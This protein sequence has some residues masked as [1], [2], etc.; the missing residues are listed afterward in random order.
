MQQTITEQ[1]N[2]A[3]DGI[4]RLRAEQRKPHFT[5]PEYTMK[6]IYDAIPPHCLKSNTLLSL[7]YIA[8][9]FVQ[10]F[11]L[12]GLATF[13][14]QI[15]TASLR[16]CAWAI[17]AFVQGLCFTGLWEIAHESGHGALS[18]HKWVN[19]AIGMI[20]HSLLLVPFHSW[21]LTHAQ[22]HKSTN[23]LERDIAFVP[24]VK[25]VYLEKKQ[26]RAEG[27]LT[28]FF[29]MV[30]DTPIATMAFLF[31]HQLIAWPLYLTINNRAIPRIAATP[32]Y[33]GSHFYTGGDGPNF[34]PQNGREILIS[35]LGIGAMATL[36]YASV[37]YFG[38]W[39]V[40]LIYLFPWLWTN[41]WILT[42]TYLQ[43]TDLSLP[44]YPTK[45]WSFLRG[46]AS[47]I[48]RDFGWIGRH[49]IHGAIECHV[50]H[51]H[52]SRIPFYH[53]AEAS[54]A[55]RKVMGTHYQSDFETSYMWA[56]W[57]VHRDCVHVEEKDKESEVYFFSK[58]D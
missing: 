49:L 39:N 24:D 17:Y 40:A 44:Y 53:A 30:E 35:D 19:S 1:A 28:H 18:P 54:Q 51:H 38:G 45:T 22:H 15:P 56:F 34:K 41:H 6:D 9:D 5:P 12:I 43:H 27:K 14:P 11:A 33:K 10:C 29:E 16:F 55:I 31:F 2:V 25:E 46:A 52:C 7:A 37:Q 21:K 36:L 8:W 50:V 3:E 20:T 32:W 48:D 47:T 4:I 13:I 23:N 26:E 42:I 57:K 58:K